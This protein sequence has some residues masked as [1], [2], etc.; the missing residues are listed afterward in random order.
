[1]LLVFGLASVA[2]SQVPNGTYII[3]SAL[4]PNFVIDLNASRI[5]D[6]NNIQLWEYNG[7]NAQKWVV[8]SV[9]SISTIRSSIDRNYV[10]DLSSAN[11]NDGNNIHLWRANGT[12]AQSWRIITTK[13]GYSAIVSV[14][15]PDGKLHVI[16]LDHSVVRQGQNI[17]IWGSN[18]TN[19]QRWWFDRVD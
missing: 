17:Q 9:G 13:S 19:A 18:D 15:K 3:R 8:E 10:I 4:N 11:T 1:M 12:K 14:L 7:T 5:Q 2:D 16:D 6:G